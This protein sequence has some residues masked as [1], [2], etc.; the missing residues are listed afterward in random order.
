MQSDNKIRD[1]LS[2]GKMIFEMAAMG[3]IYEDV[4]PTLYKCYTNV[5]CLLEEGQLQRHT[6]GTLPG[7]SQNSVA[8]Y[9][10]LLQFKNA[11][12]IFSYLSNCPNAL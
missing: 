12:I 6:L 7:I 4:E 10:K 11:Q 5:L 2:F 9:R 8:S 1:F 3:F